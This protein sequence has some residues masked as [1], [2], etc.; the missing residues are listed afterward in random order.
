MFDN[1]QD[2][3]YQN[4]EHFSGKNV[5]KGYLLTRHDSFLD[6][7]VGAFYKKNVL[8]NAFFKYCYLDSEHLQTSLACLVMNELAAAQERDRECHPPDQG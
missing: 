4:L 2:G 3:K 7:L 6:L 1:V 5:C 8:M